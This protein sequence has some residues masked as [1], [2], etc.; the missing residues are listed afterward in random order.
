M[1]SVPVSGS[2][3]GELFARNDLAQFGEFFVCAACQPA[4]VRQYRQGM[5]GPAETPAEF[6]YAGL[7]NASRGAVGRL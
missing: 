1:T 4:W 6:R 3:C 7:L 2:S 5:T